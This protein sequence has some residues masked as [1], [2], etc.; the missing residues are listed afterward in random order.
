MERAV[1]IDS[2]GSDPILHKPVE[3]CRADSIGQGLFHFCNGLPNGM[4]KF[5]HVIVC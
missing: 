2:N 5:V 1:G 3:L 4:D